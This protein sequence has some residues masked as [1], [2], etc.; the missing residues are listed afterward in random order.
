MMTTSAEHC[1]LLRGKTDIELAMDLTGSYAEDIGFD[2]KE[3][4]FLKLMTEE[5]C[6]NVVD[7]GRM[8]STFWLK[9]ELYKDGMDLMISQIGSPYSINSDIELQ[10]EASRGR[11][12]YIIR[13]LCDSMKVEQRG[14]VTSLII[15]KR[16]KILSI[17]N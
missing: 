3:T 4:I 17:T 14:S 15:T 5:A 8:Y 13:N 2:S 16:R 7:H 1:L 9:W 11:G 10:T 12:L 6:M